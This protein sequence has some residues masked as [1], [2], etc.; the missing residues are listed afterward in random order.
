MTK[1]NLQAVGGKE[2]GGE[3]ALEKRR[4]SNLKDSCHAQGNRDL[5]SREEKARD[6]L[7]ERRV[8]VGKGKGGNAMQCSK[9]RGG[10]AVFQEAVPQPNPASW[11]GPKKKEGGRK[12]TSSILTGGRSAEKEGARKG[13]CRRPPIWM[14]KKKGSSGPVSKL[15]GKGKKGESII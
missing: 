10:G 6:N 12:E 3:A 11:G 1:K 7:E 8:Q 15:R 2:G 14:G 4:A 9:Q 13:G 5:S